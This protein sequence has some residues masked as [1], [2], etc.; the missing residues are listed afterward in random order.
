M[1]DIYKEQ[2]VKKTPGIK[3]MSMK[4]GVVALFAVVSTTAV[5]LLAG[6]LGTY[7]FFIVLA[8]GFLVFYVFSYL[9]VEH[10]YIFTNG[11]L[12][13]D[14][15]YNKSR[16]K[17][18]FSGD[19]K[20]IVIMTHIDEKGYESEFKRAQA[21]K[22]CTSGTRNENTYK[23]LANYNGKMILFYFEPNETM[24]AVMTP[25]LGQKRFVKK[26]DPAE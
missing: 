12:D 17:T 13:I 20:N 8:L 16:R 5:M 25:Y 22:D 21:T 9:Q 26:I 19:V 3:A 11:D 7:V 6:I 15:I 10:E 23:F 24:L 14:L 2:L 18:V 4:I 1:G